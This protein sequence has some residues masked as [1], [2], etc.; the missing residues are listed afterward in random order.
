M[1]LTVNIPTGSGYRLNHFLEVVVNTQTAAFFSGAPVWLDESSPQYFMYR[2]SGA[3][4]RLQK[5][6]DYPATFVQQHGS[7]LLLGYGDVRQARELL[8]M[9][10]GSI[11]EATFM[12][13]E[14][15]YIVIDLISGVV[16][17]QCDAFSTVPLF[18][19]AGPDRFIL[20]SDFATVH[21]LHKTW[22]YRL[23]KRVVAQFLAGQ[24]TFGQ[25][26]VDEI[27]VL[28]DRKRLVWRAGNPTIYVPPDASMR[29][30]HKRRTADPHTFVP[31]L[32]QTLDSYWRR[33]VGAGH[34]GGSE[35]SGGLDSA[36]V[37]AYLADRGYK[38]TTLTSVLPGAFGV[39]Q[40]RKIEAF[41]QRFSTPSIK[42]P[43]HHQLDYPWQAVLD[44]RL[45]LPFYHYEYAVYDTDR[46]V[47]YQEL[48]ASGARAVF[49]GVGGDELFEHV[50]HA[51]VMT[52]RHAYAGTYL[53]VP[54]FEPLKRCLSAYSQAENVRR[55]P[56]PLRPYS[57][58][59]MSLFA[60]TA[61][62]NGVWPVAPLGD[63][64]L[65][66]FM[67]TMPLVYCDAKLLFA[68]YA[69]ARRMPKSMYLSPNNED[70]RDVN[71]ARYFGLHAYITQALSN[72][73]LQDMGLIRTEPLLHM[74]ARA[75]KLGRIDSLMALLFVR[76]LYAELNL[77]SLGF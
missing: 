43:A 21:N 9:P 17:V 46:D 4:I 34:L 44:H 14:F 68:I 45:S 23:N 1:T 27:Q 61:L 12:S 6:A 33:Y 69:R 11:T 66:A 36:V 18:V 60:T 56:I 10:L 30:Y 7:K 48:Y 40:Q 76:L 13:D 32:E 52:N 47:M 39:S 62:R 38:P 29:D 63:P 35:L 42:R 73:L 51:L 5:R 25:T 67:Q 37:T 59:Q 74:H 16:T 55:Q 54:G 3:T 24:D 26:F 41:Q 70:F 75:G 31:V 15:L 50:D 58:L 20:A 49:Q 8:S 65:Y 53:D 77:R 22:R 71:V 19:A 57:V 72:S 64:R 2:S 28:Y